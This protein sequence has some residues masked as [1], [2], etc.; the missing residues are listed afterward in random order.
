MDKDPRFTHLAPLWDRS[1]G[2][3]CLLAEL[4]SDSPYPQSMN[5]IFSCVCSGQVENFIYRELFTQTGTIQ[6]VKAGG[7]PDL[8]DPFFTKL[9]VCYLLNCLHNRRL[10]RCNPD[11]YRLA[12]HDRYLTNVLLGVAKTIDE[13]GYCKTFDRIRDDTV[14]TVKQETLSE[15]RNGYQKAFPRENDIIFF[16]RKKIF[17]TAA[18]SRFL[19]HLDSDT[20]KC[21]CA[22]SAPKGT[23]E[24]SVKKVRDG[25]IDSFEELVKYLCEC[26]RNGIADFP[27]INQLW[28]D[29]VGSPRSGSIIKVRP[30]D[31]DLQRFCLCLALPLETLKQLIKL[32]D[33]NPV[34][35]KQL[36]DRKTA[37]DRKRY[38]S[39]KERSRSERINEF[40]RN[41][42]T[43]LQAARIACSDPYSL[44][45][46]MLVQ[47]SG[48][49]INSGYSGMIALSEDELKRLGISPEKY[50]LSHTRAPKAKKT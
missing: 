1:R 29:A 50:K 33:S 36:Q 11:L 21:F 34:F 16:L 49:L 47:A 5:A 14:G 13:D 23:I 24:L 44:P 40:L 4:L 27:S 48:E 43:R 19:F 18:S 46:E 7:D 30:S 12:V 39:K 25:E 22:S 3:G 38:I 35:Q 41:S 42:S 10:E 17:E 26:Q 31:R 32:R 45:H 37:T 28:L 8:D 20:P 2:A 15:T 9:V 6:I